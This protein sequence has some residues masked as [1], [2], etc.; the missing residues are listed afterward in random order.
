[1]TDTD[2]AAVHARLSAVLE[3][4]LG[5]EAVW[6][7]RES[8]TCEEHGNP[9]VPWSSIAD[10]DYRCLMCLRPLTPRVERRPVDWDD[11]AVLWPRWERWATDWMPSRPPHTGPIDTVLRLLRGATNR[12]LADADRTITA[13]MAT[14]WDAL[15]AKEVRDD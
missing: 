15:L 1:M 9:E 5:T 14:A 4:T 11:P 12:W 3:A 8:Y 13:E 7:F 2:R 6:W 10:A